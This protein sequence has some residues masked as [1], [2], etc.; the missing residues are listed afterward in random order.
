MKKFTIGAAHWEGEEYV[1]TVNGRPMGPTVS[2]SA[3]AIIH[4]WLF[5]ALP[6]IW[7]ALNGQ[8][9]MV[10]EDKPNPA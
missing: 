2:K 8:H 6:D 9:L 3:A 7:E 5:V 1:I 10:V 4:E